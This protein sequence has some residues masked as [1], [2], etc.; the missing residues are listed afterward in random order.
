MKQ[1][2]TRS[3]KVMTPPERYEGRRGEAARLLG[4]DKS[5]PWRKMKCYGL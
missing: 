4:M 1:L 3:C 5:T 2:F